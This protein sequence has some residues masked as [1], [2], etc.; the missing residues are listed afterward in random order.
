MDN[1]K[2]LAILSGSSSVLI[3]DFKARNDEKGVMDEEKVRT[4][5]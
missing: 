4:G 3:A 2:S 1:S 5:F